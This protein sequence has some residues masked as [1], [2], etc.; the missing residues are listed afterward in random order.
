MKLLGSIISGFLISPFALAWLALYSIIINAIYDKV[1]APMA[2]LY[3]QEWP[4]V[5]FW[6]W[7]VLS[8]LIT[9]VNFAFR[10]TSDK[11]VSGKEAGESLC[12]RIGMMT[13]F[14][15]MA[16]IINWIWL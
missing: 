5:P 8:M 14:L 2:A 16:Y 6:H 3:G 13:A 7:I 11:N 10:G 15:A 12:K 1:L 9:F 4:D